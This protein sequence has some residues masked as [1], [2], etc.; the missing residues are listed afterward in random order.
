[1]SEG[2]RVGPT[3]AGLAVAFL[4]VYGL[5][6]WTGW[7]SNP[8]DQPNNTAQTQQQ[9]ADTADNRPAKPDLWP[10]FTPSDT[11]AQWASAFL[12]LIGAGISVWAVMLVRDTLELNQTATR[13]AVAGARAAN[14]A[15]VIE[16]RPWIRFK[17]H[18]TGP[19]IFLGGETP[20][21]FFTM[22]VTFTN[23][24]KTLAQEI[25][26]EHLPLRGEDGGTIESLDQWVTDRR[27]AYVNGTER[28]ETIF[29]ND[30]GFAWM[31][32]HIDASFRGVV[33][34]RTIEPIVGICITYRS[35]IDR[36]EVFQTTE[37]F[38]ITHIDFQNALMAGGVGIPTDVEFVEGAQLLA[39]RVVSSSRA[40]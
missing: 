19:L 15:L 17:V 30:D 37:A 9:K 10:K 32:P 18:I 25:V 31:S 33:R 13:A 14:R 2:N 23:V 8:A 5:G 7:S 26:V 40:T 36:D 11:Y 1:M 29:P 4:A 39:W 28:G 3:L 35:P 34:P 21:V 16:N 38:A 12:A 27:A 20:L 22:R 24:G 6:V